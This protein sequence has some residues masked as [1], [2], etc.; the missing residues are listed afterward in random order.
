MPP[1]LPVPEDDL[2]NRFDISSQDKALLAE[3]AVFPEDEARSGTFILK[4]TVGL[5]SYSRTEGMELLPIAEALDT[6]DWVRERYFRRLA[7]SPIVPDQPEVT[8]TD[9]L[10]GYFL[11]VKKGEH[12]LF[13]SQTA[14]CMTGALER[15]FI[16]NI[17]ILEE[18]SSLELITGCIADTRMAS[19]EHVAVTETYIGK[20]ADFTH[21]M[22]HSWN[23]QVRVRPYSVTE[24]GKGGRYVSN[25]VSL[26]PAGVTESNPV[27]YLNGA[28]A[29]A[30]YFSILLGLEG[31]SITVGGDVYLN[32]PETGAEIAHRAVCTGGKI[33]QKGMLYGNAACRAHVDCAGMLITPGDEGFIESIPGLRSRHPDARMSHEASIG[34]IAPR[35]VHYLMAQG[36]EEREAVSMIVRGFLDNNIRGLGE[37]LDRRIAEIAELAG[38]GEE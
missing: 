10:S 25:Y 31:A 18:G 37:E 1:V 3:V 32:A 8:G 36:M 13:P 22:V 38:H 19:G 11:W 9:R 5:C 17:I 30:K 33:V 23:P 16:H 26:R 34:K 21:T 35:Q 29:S 7:V 2:M 12:V 14:L 20:N 24:V 15:Q 4:D 6:F 28:G 27:T